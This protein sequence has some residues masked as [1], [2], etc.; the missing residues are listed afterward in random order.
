[1]ATTQITG[2][3]ELDTALKALPLR[4]R[5]LVADSAARA[6]AN[7]IKREWVRRAPRGAETS[8]LREKF[9]PLH[10]NIKVKRM[11]KLGPTAT[12]F[13]IHEG[14]AFWAWF[15]EF[16]TGQPPQP[17][18]RPGFDA[19]AQPSIAAM[20]KAFKTKFASISKQLAGPRSKISKAVRR[21]I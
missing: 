12:G 10:K 9:G 2:L 15:V 14:N 3:R 20:T 17:F 5:E 7:T 13:L 19:A 6:G 21:R 1:M 16:G 8:A 4:V 11:T 18:A